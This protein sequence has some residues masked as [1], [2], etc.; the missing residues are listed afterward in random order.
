MSLSS[1]GQAG[2]LTD[3]VITPQMIEAGSA[4]LDAA[5]FKHDYA[6]PIGPYSLDAI[7]REVFAAMVAAKEHP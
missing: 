7:A 1:K 4:A 6:S 5:L 2:E 3:L